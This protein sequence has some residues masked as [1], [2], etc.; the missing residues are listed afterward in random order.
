[1]VIIMAKMTEKAALKITLLIII[2]VSL[3][4]VGCSTQDIV[5]TRNNQNEKLTVGFIAP[6]TG[7]LASFT[8]P[9]KRGVELAGKE[10]N[11]NAEFEMELHFEDGR[12]TGKDGLSAYQKLKTIHNIDAVIVMCSAE[13]LAIAPEAAKTNTLII[14]PSA[15]APKI[16][17]AG[18][19]V[20]RVTTSDMLQGK[21]GAKLIQELGYT[22][23]AML[24]T[25]NDY[26]KGLFT[27]LDNDLGQG[28][29]IAESFLPNTKD[30]R[31][32]VTKIKAANVDVLYLAALPNEAVTIFKQLEELGLEIPI[33]AAE[34]IKDPQILEY[35]KNVIITVPKA[36]GENYGLFAQKYIAE[37]GQKPKLYSAEA[38]DATLLVAEAFTRN[39][40]LVQ[41]MDSITSYN[42]AAGKISFDANG[43]ITKPY[44]LFIVKDGDFVKV[45]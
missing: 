19:H 42:G 39:K 20:F 32:Q 41:G 13:T 11:E 34:A 7:D 23:A 18:K 37:F 45:G 12:C 3:V 14:S 33:I 22:R 8:E 40:N 10:I 2:V 16:T 9:I 24:Y 35:A 30:V 25:N 21:E 43:D 38:Y 28:L 29:V 36:K 31:S 15:T 26:G 17:N 5:S 1:M 27:V 6:L 4:L 44:E